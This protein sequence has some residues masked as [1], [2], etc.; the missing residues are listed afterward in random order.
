[1]TAATVTNN[2]EKERD[3]MKAIIMAAGKGSRISEKINGVPKCTL[4]MPNGVPI[5][6]RT[7]DMMLACGI[8]PVLCIGYQGEQIKKALSGLAVKYYENPFFSVTNNIA[9]V[10]FCLPELDGTD[11]IMLLSG[12]LF[13]S[14]DFL[15]RAKAAAAGLNLFVDSGQIETGDYFFHR[16]GAGFVDQYGPRL[17]LKLRECANV[18]IA[19]ISAPLAPAFAKKVREFVLEE[20]YQTYFEE[21]LLAFSGENRER[22]NLIDVRGS[23]WREFDYYEDYQFILDHEREGWE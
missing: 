18:G 20:R 12:D 7:V 23:F 14:V 1:M 2:R 16:D 10:W 17:P 21:V 9:S 4:P 5:I 19:K 8:E 22:I 13:Y 11:D 15:A 6:R 3:R